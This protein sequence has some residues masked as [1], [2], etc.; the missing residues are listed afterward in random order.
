M[1]AIYSCFILQANQ[2]IVKEAD[3]TKTGGRIVTQ[4]SRMFSNTYVQLL[5]TISIT[6]ALFRVK[7]ITIETASLTTEPC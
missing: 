2:G 5:N 1:A 4:E 6:S 7:N 3:S